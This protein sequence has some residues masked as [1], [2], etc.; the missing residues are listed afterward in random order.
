MQL[1]AF[2]DRIR[3]SEVKYS[4]TP[5][6]LLAQADGIRIC[7]G[8]T[9]MLIVMERPE[10]RK[11]Q[12]RPASRLFSADSEHN[13]ESDCKGLV[14]V[15]SEL[16]NLLEDYSPAWYTEEHQRWLESALHGICL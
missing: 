3:C 5:P 7:N 11:P 1:Q 12:N 16:R 4:L 8:G 15:L 9:R 13:V 2:C 6:R 14:E 10:T